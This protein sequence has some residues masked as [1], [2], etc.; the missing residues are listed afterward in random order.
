MKLQEILDLFQFDE[1]AAGRTLESVSSVP[2]AKYLEDLKSSH[3]GM[4]G[5]LV[6]IYTSSLIWLQRWQGNTLP[7]PV[8]R[9]EIPNLESLKSHCRE[10]RDRLG[11]YLANLDEEA[12]NRPFSYSD[13]KG[14]RQ[15]EPLFQQMQ[16]LVNHASYHRGQVVTMLRQIG[17]KPTGT[18]LI[19]FYRTRS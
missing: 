12:L 1:W 10:Y 18:D 19:T 14:N 11:A 6:H 2:E 5:T 8:T 3:G 17:S 7:G 13:L 9:V 4:H 16:H 15:S